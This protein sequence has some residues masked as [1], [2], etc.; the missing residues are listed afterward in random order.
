MKATLAHLAFTTDSTRLIALL[1]KL[2]GFSE[3][4][5]G[6][7]TD[8]HNLSH[9]VGREDK[10][11]ELMNLELAQF[12]KPA[13][14]LKRLQASQEGDATLLDRTQILYG[15]NHDNKN[16]PVIL[17]GGGYK[18]GQHLAFDKASNYP[19]SN[20]YVSM[21]QRLGLETAKFSSSTAP[22]G[23]W[24]WRDTKP[25]TENDAEFHWNFGKEAA[26]CKPLPSKP[27]L[28]TA[29]MAA[30]SISK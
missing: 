24:R 30:F 29:G 8:A 13:A 20:L 22:C 18:H 9:H 7:S 27:A 6:V 4:I 26:P 16:I 11:K 25:R 1:V 2:E 21:L 5:S 17:A 28:P 19:L 23:G 15:N 14:V 12:Q 3:H 10:L